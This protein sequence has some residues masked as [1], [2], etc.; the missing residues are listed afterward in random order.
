MRAAASLNVPIKHGG[1]LMKYGSISARLSGFFKITLPCSSM[2]WILKTFFARPM[3][4]V[5][6]CMSVAPVCSS[7][8]VNTSTLAHSDA[9]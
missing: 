9:A 4:N 3:P 8:L 2:P 5:V 1:R 6:T 7:G